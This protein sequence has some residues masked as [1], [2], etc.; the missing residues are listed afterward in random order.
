MSQDKFNNNSKIRDKSLSL[1]NYLGLWSQCGLDWSLTIKEEIEDAVAQPIEENKLKHTKKVVRFSALT[2][3]ALLG[4]AIWI[5][6]PKI[7]QTVQE[8][9]RNSV[10]Q[11]NAQAKQKI[12]GNY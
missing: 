6:A 2:I 7:Y 8:V 1:L 3:L 12:G 9:G 4:T 10:E 5:L 11:L